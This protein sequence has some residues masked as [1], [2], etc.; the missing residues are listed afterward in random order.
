MQNNNP[1]NWINENRKLLER[2]KGEWIAY[3]V[4]DVLLIHDKILSNVTEYVKSIN[5]EFI[6]WFVP[7]HWGKLLQ[8]LPIHL[9][10]V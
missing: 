6:L 3:N 9:E 1:N 8:F 10:R 5:K 4:E 2:F 7:R